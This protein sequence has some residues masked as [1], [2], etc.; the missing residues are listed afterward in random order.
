MRTMSPYY[1]FPPFR[2][3][4]DASGG[5][6]LSRGRKREISLGE[7]IWAVA[8]PAAELKGGIS[9]RQQ[10]KNQW[11]RGGVRQSLPYPRICSLRMNFLLTYRFRCNLRLVGDQKG[12]SNCRAWFSAHKISRYGVRTC[13]IHDPPYFWSKFSTGHPEKCCFFVNYTQRI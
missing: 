3:A 12:I 6:T 5:S 8:I 13:K 9:G 10:K 11:T 1:I 4:S 7:P 2:E